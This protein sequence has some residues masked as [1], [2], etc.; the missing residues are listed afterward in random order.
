MA[1]ILLTGD[2]HLGRGY[3]KEEASVSKK[4]SDARIVALENIIK[5]GNN[6]SC[7]YVVIAGDLYDKLTG[8]TSELHK[9][10]CDIL[11]RFSG[12][13]ILILPGNH[14]FYDEKTDKLWVEF[15]KYSGSNVRLFKKNEKWQ[16]GNI[17][18]YPCICN[19]KW[20]KDNSL[21]WVKE[22]RIRDDSLLHIGIAHGA[23]EGLS[24]DKK[25]EYYYMTNKELADCKMDV[26]LIGHMHITY[27]QVFDSTSNNRVFNAGTHQQTDISDNSNSVVLILDISSDKKIAAKAIKTGVIDFVK[28]SVNIKHGESLVDKLEFKDIDATKT[29]LR[30]EISGIAKAEEYDNR[31]QIYEDVR[32]KYL[33]AEFFDSNLRKEITAEMINKETLEGTLINQLLHKYADDMELLNLAY[34]LVDKCKYDKKGK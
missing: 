18:F 9:Q 20:S 23:V 10:V 24:Y 5:V 3:Q 12:E 27:P 17:V 16:D 34:D 32:S 26:W 6:E 21:G 7:D 30:V 31:G 15:E 28:R 19:S 33:K 29:S 1:R 13:S 11:D 22:D 2:L 14:D 8:I 4:I 25:Q